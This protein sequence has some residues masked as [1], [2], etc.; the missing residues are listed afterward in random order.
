[1][2]MS[3]DIRVKTEKRYAGLYKDLKEYAMGDS[4]EVFFLCAC[5][6]FKRG[7]RTPLKNSEDRFWSKT[8]SSNE[9]SSYYAMIVKEND[10]DFSSIANDKDVLS[11]IEQYANFGIEILLKDFLSDYLAKDSPEPRID[12]TVSKELGKSLL[13]QIY[14]KAKE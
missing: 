8:I 1:M 3:V 6:G 10:F 9:Y 12:R 2:K 7:K 14:A 13:Y 11:R 4:H 5:L